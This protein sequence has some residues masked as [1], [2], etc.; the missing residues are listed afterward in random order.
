MC[1]VL[2]AKSP[3]YLTWYGVFPTSSVRM[4]SMIIAALYV[5]LTVLD[6]VGL[7]GASDL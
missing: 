3:L 7:R 4:L 5:I 2:F 1:L 6:P